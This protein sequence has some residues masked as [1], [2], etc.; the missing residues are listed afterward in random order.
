MYF[1]YIQPSIL[2]YACISLYFCYSSLWFHVIH[3]HMYKW[4]YVSIMNSNAQE[5]KK[6][7]CLPF[8]IWFL[9]YNMIILSCI[10]E[11]A[12]FLFLFSGSYNQV[13]KIKLYCQY[14]LYFSSWIHLLM[15][16]IPQLGF[17]KYFCKKH[18]C[19]DNFCATLI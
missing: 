13:N 18:R 12:W 6:I 7:W 11:A 1:R 10:Q 3:T 15:I 17:S 5:L 8:Y 14:I 2:F 4:F 9:L 19:A 16:L